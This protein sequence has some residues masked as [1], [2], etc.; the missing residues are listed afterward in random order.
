MQK[1][2]SFPNS[3]NNTIFFV[4][5]SRKGVSHH[6]IRA[7]VSYN[8][9]IPRQQTEKSSQDKAKQCIWIEVRYGTNSTKLGSR[10]NFHPIRVEMPTEVPPVADKFPFFS[11]T[12]YRLIGV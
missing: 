8:K 11:N 6:F 2:T 9:E 3:E 10:T 1:N 7:H 12:H 5:L 4:L